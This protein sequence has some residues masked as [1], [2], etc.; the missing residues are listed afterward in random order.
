MSQFSAIVSAFH[1]RG[2]LLADEVYDNS[3]ANVQARSVGPVGADDFDRDR[4]AEYETEAYE[5]IHEVC[6]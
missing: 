6:V 5:R 2:F 3:V 1:R 4:H